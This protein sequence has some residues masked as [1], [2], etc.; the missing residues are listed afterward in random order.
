MSK[1]K[2]IQRI[3][4]RYKD[5][6][7]VHEVVMLEVAKWAVKHGYPLPRPVNPI[8]RL[9][10][11]FSRAARDEIKHDEK[12]GLPYRA[13]HAVSTMSGGQ[14]LTFW[15][16]IDEAT[17]STMLKSLIQRREQMVD[18]GFQLTLDADH[19]NNMNQSEEPIQIPLDFTEDIEERKNLPTNTRRAS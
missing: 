1:T 19:W 2:E 7:G 16:D 10:H 15:I 11:D 14:Q 8:D 9:A 18:D 13:N 4:R 5:E 17:R 6:T 12:T 3:I